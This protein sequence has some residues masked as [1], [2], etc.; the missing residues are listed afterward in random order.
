MSKSSPSDTKQDHSQQ[1]QN[2]HG[3]KSENGHTGEGAASAMAHM[4]SQDRKHRRQIG[5]ADEPG[6]GSGHP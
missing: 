5:D 6:A 3:E 2:V 4:I 1:D